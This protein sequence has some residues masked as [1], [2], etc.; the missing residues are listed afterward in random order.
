MIIPR[1]AASKVA[2][3]IAIVLVMVEVDGPL[4]SDGGQI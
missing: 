4:L 3:L 1:C 2:A